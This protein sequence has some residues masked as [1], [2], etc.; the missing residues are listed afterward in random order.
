MHVLSRGMGQFDAAALE[1]RRAELEEV[2][3]ERQR[4][5][6][7]LRRLESREAGRQQARQTVRERG[8]PAEELPPVKAAPPPAGFP[9]MPLVLAGGA[10]LVVGLAM[11]GRS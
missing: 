9:V 1:K 4:L 5:E 11:R 3:A 8:G 6:E 2:R 10:L 7:E